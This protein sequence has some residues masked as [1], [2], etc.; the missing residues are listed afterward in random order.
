MGST[1]AVRAHTRD[2]G[3]VLVSVDAAAITFD[4]PGRPASRAGRPL[5]TDRQLIL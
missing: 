5:P 4:E 2:S 3:E 1:M